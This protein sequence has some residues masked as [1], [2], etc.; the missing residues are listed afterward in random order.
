M[1]CTDVVASCGA[2]IRQIASLAEVNH[3]EVIST[4]RCNNPIEQ[5]HRPT[6]RQ[7]R[8]QQGF[9]RRKRA[10]EFLRLHARIENLHQRFRH[11]Q[12]KELEARVPDVV[13]GRGRGSMNPRP[14]CPY[15]RNAK[16][17]PYVP[18]GKA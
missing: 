11:D 17:E 1:I 14:P 4:A 10:Q 2:A 13:N 7:E 12:T 8:Q 16:C 18:R 5:S 6:R 15:L 3:Q 9:D